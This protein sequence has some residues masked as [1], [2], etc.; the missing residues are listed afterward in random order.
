[1]NYNLK[2]FIDKFE[3]IPE[4]NWCSGTFYKEVT[5]LTKKKIMLGFSKSIINKLDTF[6]VQ[7]HCMGKD[8]VVHTKNL[9]RTISLDKIA[10][11]FPEWSKLLELTGGVM[12]ND[13]IIASINNGSNENYC[14]LTP[15]QRVLAALY[16]IRDG[17]YPY[18][19]IHVL[20]NQLSEVKVDIRG[21]ML[22]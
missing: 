7:G 21:L 4:E 13:I 1:M 15:K 22:N 19:T 5:V 10:K 20:L 3:S 14:Q 11:S 9:M 2:Y 18:K 16:D 6:C 8:V 12:N 17:K